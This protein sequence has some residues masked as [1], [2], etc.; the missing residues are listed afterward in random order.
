VITA[1]LTPPPLNITTNSDEAPSKIYQPQ[2]LPISPPSPLSPPADVLAAQES[3][4]LVR[5]LNYDITLPDSS[6]EEPEDADEK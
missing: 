5:C 3:L 6:P 1:A 2:P 4:E